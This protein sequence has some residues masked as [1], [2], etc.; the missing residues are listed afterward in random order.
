MGGADRS[1]CTATVAGRVTATVVEGDRRAVGVD[2]RGTA[3]GCP[4]LDDGLAVAT[5]D[6]AVAPG[7]FGGVVVDLV[8]EPAHGLPAQI[9][10]LAGKGVEEM[11]AGERVHSARC[12]RQ[13]YR[14]RGQ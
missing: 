13:R 9:A 5:I 4:G 6:L 8:F 14:D 2:D 11:A 10:C 3:T 12:G 1:S 7:G